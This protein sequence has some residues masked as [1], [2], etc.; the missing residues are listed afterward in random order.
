MEAR[1]KSYMWEGNGRKIIALKHSIYCGMWHVPNNVFLVITM[2]TL[3]T[4]Y[5][6]LLNSFQDELTLFLALFFSWFCW[7]F[8]FVH[9]SFSISSATPNA[10]LFFA[11]TQIQTTKNHDQHLFRIVRFKFSTT[12]E[13]RLEM[14]WEQVILFGFYQYVFCIFSVFLLFFVIFY[15][16]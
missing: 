8:F 13:Q 14:L 2:C 5:F 7:N 3:R 1:I 6:I 12:L 11:C 4:Y 16:G 15:F 10:T 9:T